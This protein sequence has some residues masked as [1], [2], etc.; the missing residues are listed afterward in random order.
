MSDPERTPV[1]DTGGV[2]GGAGQ[3]G[4]HRAEAAVPPVRL[5][6]DGG[7][8]HLVP[9]LR[10]ALHLRVGLHVHAG[11]RQRERRPPA[12]PGAVRDDVRHHAPLRRARQPADRPDRRRDARAARGPRVRPR[13]PAGRP[14]APRGPPV[15][16][17]SPPR[18]RTSGDHRQPDD[19][20]RDLLRRSSPSRCSSRSGPAA[21]TRAPPTTTPPAATSAAPRTAW[22]SPA[23]TCRPPRSWASPAPSPSTA[24]T[25]SCTRSAS[26]SPGWWRCCWSPS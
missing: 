18:P 26:S 23:T 1:A 13:R 21:T 20:H 9:A 8:L 19:Q 6:D 3:P 14:R 15:S 4:V 7:L 12:G 24:T 2:P 11:V 25:A 10:P 17:L 22:R 16:D 5:P